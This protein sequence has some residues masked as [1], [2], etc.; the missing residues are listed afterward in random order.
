MA[1]QLDIRY[2][3]NMGVIP[4]QDA[5]TRFI[6]EPSLN[7]PFE[8]DVKID[9]YVFSG[10]EKRLV[11]RILVRRYLNGVLDSEFRKEEEINAKTMV[12]YYG[13]VIEKVP[14]IKPVLDENGNPTGET[15]EVM[16]YP[17]EAVMSEWDR[18]A[19]LFNAPISDS[20]VL[21]AYKAQ[22]FNNGKLYKP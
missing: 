1:Q 5:F 8:Y 19:I 9:N 6:P 11:G 22:I 20:L 7:I 18:L 12:D 17:S 15:E 10:S 21:D 2:F 16:E 13:N 3:L 4:Y 14:V